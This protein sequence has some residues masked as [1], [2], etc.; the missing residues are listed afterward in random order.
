MASIV[1]QQLDL[2]FEFDFGYY[3]EQN[4]NVIEINQSKKDIFLY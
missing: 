4:N 2:F 1:A 3:D